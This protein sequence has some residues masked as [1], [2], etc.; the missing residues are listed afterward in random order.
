MKLTNQQI[1]IIEQTLFSKGLV[2]EDIKLEVLDHIASEIEAE[3]NL[4]QESFEIVFKSVLQKWKGVLLTTSNSIWLGMLFQAPQIAVDKLVSYSKK[5]A[6]T[7]LFLSVVFAT[8]CSILGYSIRIE[9]F[10][11][12]LQTTLTGMF[13][14][15]VGLTIIS[16]FL[17]WRS[18]FKTTF[19]RLFLY[20]GWVVFVFFFM[21]SVDNE[22]LKHF[23]SNHTFTENF[24][25][26]LLYGCLFF[27]SYCQIS[28]ALKHFKIVSKFK[29]V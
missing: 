27:Y 18:S 26:C 9:L 17:I 29:M 1:A 13:Y 11:N 24:I 8:L 2:Y 22:P 15:M 19:G 28:M 12:I 5:Q 25:S 7:V 4:E 14:V 6:L 23:D 20:R 3:I 21:S 10:S 16:L